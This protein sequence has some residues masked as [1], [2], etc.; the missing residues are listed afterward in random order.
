[1]KVRFASS[2]PGFEKE[3]VDILNLFY[4]SVHLVREPFESVDLEVAFHETGHESGRTCTVTLNGLTLSMHGEKG[5]NALLDKRLRKR[6][7]K[8]SL[9]EALVKS[10]GQIPPWGSLTGIRPT[11]LVYEAMERGLDL[12]STVKEVLGTFR[13]RE[14]KADLLRQIISVQEG[15][16]AVQDHEVSCYIGVP[17]CRTRCRYC[18][19]ISSEVGD[20]RLLPEYTEALVREIEG[21]IELMKLRGKKARSLYIG[22][23]TPTTLSQEEL[24][25]VMLAAK[26]LIDEACEV[27]VEAGRP[28]TITKGKLQAI[29]DHG[30]TRISINPQTMFDRT[31]ALIGR[32]HTWEQTLSA[33]SLARELGFTHINMDLI[34]GLPGE[35]NEMFAQTLKEVLQLRPEALTVHTLALKRSSEMHRLSDPLPQGEIVAKMVRLASEAAHDAGM[36]PYYLYRQKHMAGNLENVGYAKPGYACLYNIDMM[37]DRTTILAM[38]AGAVSKLVDHEKKRILRAPNVK[39]VLQYIS[40][41][42]EM[43]DKKNALFE[44]VGKGVKPPEEDEFRD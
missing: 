11:R 31:L 17:F 43:L 40:R 3:L 39:D 38:G 16:P 26:P 21:T 27:T 13:L 14:D 34:A 42:S 7:Y 5:A 33:F 10:T 28:D 12:K 18:S 24:R 25:K 36:Q 44:G 41:V 9:F 37:E 20:G 19:F 15:L 29:K 1:M 23:G 32:D 4:G 22:G 30:A 35:S 8:M 6:L 2:V